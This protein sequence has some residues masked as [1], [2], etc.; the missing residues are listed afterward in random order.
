MVHNKCG[1]R[2]HGHGHGKKKDGSQPVVPPRSA[3]EIGYLAHATSLIQTTADMMY[4]TISPQQSLSFVQIF[5]NAA[6]ASVLYTR[7]L[8]KH[9]STAFSDRCVTDLQGESGPV[10]YDDLLQLSTQTANAK[11]QAFK[12]LVKG[13]S[14]KAD[15]IL[16]L[17]V[18]IHSTA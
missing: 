1:R 6:I 7:E 13:Q 2:G 10:T 18:R 5:L 15:K 8:L 4:A 12:I 11:S 14:N 16:V 17:L 3:Q 9:D